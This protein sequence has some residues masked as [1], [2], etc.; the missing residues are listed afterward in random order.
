ML[1]ATAGVMSFKPRKYIKASCQPLYVFCPG[2]GIGPLQ[3]GWLV[4]RGVLHRGLV[5]GGVLNM[6]GRGGGGGWDRTSGY[7][8]FSALP[9][10]ALP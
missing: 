6:T 2:G 8:A 10:G 7:L 9:P 3:G 1:R 4:V 5:R